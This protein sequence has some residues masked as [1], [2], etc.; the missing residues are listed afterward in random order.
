MRFLLDQNLPPRLA[1]LLTAAGHET[2]HVSTIGMSRSVDDEILIAATEQERVLV[3]GDT[4]FGDLLAASNAAKPSVLLLRR[5]QGRRAAQLAGL[6]LDNLADVT[7]DLT[8]GAIVVFDELRIRVR[9]L[10][11]HPED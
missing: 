1:Q 8:E 3:S 11:V 4:D 9:R 6:L 10:P 7:D 5:Q 2:I